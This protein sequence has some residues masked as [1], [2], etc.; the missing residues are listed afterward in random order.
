MCY[1]IVIQANNHDFIGVSKTAPLSVKHAKTH[2]ILFFIKMVPF[3]QTFHLFGVTEPV[4]Y[5]EFI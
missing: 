4:K 1:Y 5:Y 3:W 2:K